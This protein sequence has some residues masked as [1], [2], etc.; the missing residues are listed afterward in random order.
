MRNLRRSGVLASLIVCFVAGSGSVAAAADES[1]AVFLNLSMTHGFSDATNALVETRELLREP[2]AGGTDLR[3]VDRA[4]DADVVITVLG[5]G[6]GHGELTATLRT[7]SGSIV[8]PLVPIAVG[9][10]L[11]EPGQRRAAKKPR[12]NS[13]ELCAERVVGDVRA[14]L[15]DN[16][17]R[18]RR[19]RTIA[20]ATAPTTQP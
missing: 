14:W 4:E 5:R 6:R 1:L 15:T 18:L 16:A 7:I 13:W 20:P 10:G 17:N 2:L 12:L 11:G 8:A 9:V 3:L 19:L